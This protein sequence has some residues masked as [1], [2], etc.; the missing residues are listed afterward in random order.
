[1][2]KALLLTSATTTLWTDYY[3]KAMKQSVKHFLFWIQND[4]DIAKPRKLSLLLFHGD[5]HLKHDKQTRSSPNTS[6]SY[7]HRDPHNIHLD[8]Q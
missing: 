1:M 2:L 6:S 5:C 7:A 3:V 4:N 8:S